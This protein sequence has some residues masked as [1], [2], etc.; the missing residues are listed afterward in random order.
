M[1]QM[2][3]VTARNLYEF[4]DYM[5]KQLIISII[6]IFT[7]VFALIMIGLIFLL[8]FV[9]LIGGIAALVFE[10]MMLIRLYRAKE[11]SPQN[12]LIKCFQFF[13]GVIIIT[14]IITFNP[15]GGIFASILDL[16]QTVLNLMAWK[17]LAVY[18][19]LYGTE[20]APSSGFRNVAEGIKMY[21]IS[22]YVSITTSLVSFFVGFDGSGA[23]ILILLLV[24][25]GTS[26]FLIIA[27]FKIANGMIEI[28]GRVTNMTQ[29]STQNSYMP[30]TKMPQKSSEIP[31]DN[32]GI[33]FCSQCG[34][35]I[36]PDARFCGVCGFTLK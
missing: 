33:S 15:V 17:S 8:G 5:K 31:K 10:I 32:T 23:L 29:F 6:V 36:A 1:S 4:G 19:E 26:V 34:A 25:L 21:T 30:S 3:N 27:S 18:V 24:S 16:I 11:S 13:I 35:D 2:N 9:I 22:V 12:E 20:V 14:V 7:A 28:F